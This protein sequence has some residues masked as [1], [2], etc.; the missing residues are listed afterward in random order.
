MSQTISDKLFTIRFKCDKVSHLTIKDRDVC[1][2]C[3][4]KDCNFFCPADVYE[5]DKKQKLTTVAFE[6]CIECGTCRI[7]CPSDNIEWVYPK[8]GYGMSFKMG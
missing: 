5:W 8:G 2:R 1:I 7:A 3:T 6:N 4:T